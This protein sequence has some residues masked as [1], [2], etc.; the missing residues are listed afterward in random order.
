MKI[1]NNPLLFV[2]LFLIFPTLINAHGFATHTLV[3]SNSEYWWVIE[4]VVRLS[5][6]E[7]QYVLSYDVSSEY[8]TNQQVQSGAHSTTN[9][10]VKIGV[11]HN[12]ITCTPTQ[13]FY[14]AQKEEW[15]AAYQLQ[16]GDVLLADKNNQVKIKSVEFVQEHLDVY[17][18]Q[19]KDTHTFL[20]S[21][22]SVITH[23][24]VIP[25]VAAGLSIPF[26]TG[27]SGGAMGAA[28]GPI[29][30]IGG[31][32]IGGVIGCAIKFG[33]NNKVAEYK[34]NYDVDKIGS[35]VQTKNKKE[36]KPRNKNEKGSQC[37]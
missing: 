18:I 36:E 4:Q 33:M 29:G 2:F 31:L 28:F 21:P 27:C 26:S 5:K 35:Y 19:V 12:F 22:H 23:N 9:C 1:Y 37:M 3:K 15:V 25:A 10:Y 8:W 7:K 13:E 14:L 32:A 11:P 34:L 6:K 20:V 16:A 24:M 30:F 17:S